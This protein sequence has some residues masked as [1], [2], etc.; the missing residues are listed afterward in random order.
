M[1]LDTGTASP[2]HRRSRTAAT[3][4]SAL[5]HDSQVKKLLALLA[6]ALI[7]LLA[8]MAAGPNREM[9][10]VAGSRAMDAPLRPA[11]PVTATEEPRR[12]PSAGAAAVPAEVMAP[13]ATAT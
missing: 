5:H 7:G 8:W 6:L 10:P 3:S 9:A 13:I 11:D 12:D 1:P 4:D 2:A